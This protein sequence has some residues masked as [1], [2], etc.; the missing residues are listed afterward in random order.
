MIAHLD[1]DEMR[2]LEE[3]IPAGRLAQPDEIASLVYFLSLPESVLYYRA[4]FI[5]P[6][7]GW[8]T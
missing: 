8:L 3:E 4:K 5:S 2:A 6:N 7:G 1:L